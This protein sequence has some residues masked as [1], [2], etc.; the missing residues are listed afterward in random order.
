MKSLIICGKT[1]SGKTTIA[2]KLEKLGINRIITYTTRP[3][4]TNEVDGIDYNFLSQKEFDTKKEE[5]YFAETADYATFFGHCSYGSA[6]DSYKDNSVI[7]LNPIGIK[8]LDKKSLNALVVYLEVPEDKLRMRAIKR[9]DSASE[10][11]RRL[12]ADRIDFKDI[13]NYYDIKISCDEKSPEKIVEE[14]LNIVKLFDNIS[15]KH[16]N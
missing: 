5:N 2:K 10:I 14:I 11:E 12:A 6:V 8:Q 15:F 16:S 9:G 13:E 3:P 7:V 4:R 1:N